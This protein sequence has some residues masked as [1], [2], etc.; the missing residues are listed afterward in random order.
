ME[1]DWK[2]TVDGI[3]SIEANDKLYIDSTR[4]SYTENQLTNMFDRVLQTIEYL[5]MLT[6][7]L[8]ILKKYLLSY[9][10]SLWVVIV[11]GWL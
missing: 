3:L 4:N 7:V 11:S 5:F 9:A 8:M 2:R 10:I 6:L 1:E